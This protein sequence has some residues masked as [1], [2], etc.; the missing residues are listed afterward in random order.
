MSEAG[1]SQHQRIGV[2]LDRVQIVSWAPQGRKPPPLPGFTITRDCF[3]RR[4][5]TTSTYARCRQYKRLT[6]DTKVYW[7]Y[8]R[9]KG[10]LKPWKITLVAD[11]GRGLSYE[12]IELIL[13]HCRHYRLLTVELAID[14][15]PCAGV[16]KWFVRKHAL[17]GKS[18]RREDK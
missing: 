2:Q 16:D 7:Q 8:E 11:D 4:Q 18:R 14:F 1:K 5:T 3:V 10:W 13:S 9:R 12:D 15:A 6:D 17:F